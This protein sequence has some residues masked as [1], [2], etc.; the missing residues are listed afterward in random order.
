MLRV[1]IIDS[2]AVSR[3]LLSTLLVNGGHDVVAT[4]NASSAGVARIVKLRPDIVCID[5]GH[6]NEEGAEAL[7]TVQA[8]LP[9]ALVFMVSGMFDEHTIKD[10]AARGVRGFI[11]K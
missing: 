2:N 10:G 3:D 1:A 9:K 6:K 4:S 11:V 7:A 8:A 5:I